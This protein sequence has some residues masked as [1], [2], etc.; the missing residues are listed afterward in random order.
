MFGSLWCIWIIRGNRHHWASD[1]LIRAF[2]DAI[3]ISSIACLVCGQRGW[4]LSAVATAKMCG[5]NH[6]SVYDD[7]V[8][9]VVSIYG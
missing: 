8:S 6:V 2:A 7:G 1:D 5:V 9:V 3:Y 4:P